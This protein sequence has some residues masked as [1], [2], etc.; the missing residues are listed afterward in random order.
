[1]GSLLRAYQ[2]ALQRRPVR[3]SMVASFT[4]FSAGDVI[5]QQ[6]VE[7]R[8]KDHDWTRTLRLGLYGGLIFTPIVVPWYRVI[9]RVPFASKQA[10]IA[11]KVILDQFVFAP[12]AIALF[13]S[14]TTLMEGKSIE[15]VKRKLSKSYVS[16][17]KANWTL[18]IPFQTINMAFV[19]LQHRLLAVNV[20]SLFWNTYLS[21]AAASGTQYPSQQIQKVGE[22]VEAIV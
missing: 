6:L 5:A 2:S 13:F 19:P 7:K 18:F 22:I 11:A 12:C 10:S 20:V 1:M 14:C 15:D 21:L 17:L 16:T 9:D 4:L 8:G 3:T